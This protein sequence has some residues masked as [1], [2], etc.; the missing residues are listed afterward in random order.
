M[1]QLEVGSG[2]VEGGIHHVE[3]PELNLARDPPGDG[4]HRGMI[5]TTRRAVPP[6]YVL[7]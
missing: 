4:E 5:D 3:P 2:E 1:A 6:T 7:R